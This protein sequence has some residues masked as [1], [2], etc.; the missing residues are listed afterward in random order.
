MLA[1]ILDVQCGSVVKEIQLKGDGIVTMGTS[2]DSRVLAYASAD[3]C[4]WATQSCEEYSRHE[5]YRTNPRS[6]AVSEDGSMLVLSGPAGLCIVD[7]VDGGM[8]IYTSGHSGA[9]YS[10]SSVSQSR[11]FV[12]CGQDSCARI[13]GKP[14]AGEDS[15]IARVK[16]ATTT[17]QFFVILSSDV[18]IEWWKDGPGVSRRA[19]SQHVLQDVLWILGNRAN[20]KC[21][22]GTASGR[23]WVLDCETDSLQELPYKE[24]RHPSGCA[25]SIGGS[26][27]FVQA[28][29]HVEVWDLRLGV[30][31]P[32]TG[33]DAGVPRRLAVSQDGSLLSLAYADGRLD[34]IDTLTGSRVR[35]E[36]LGNLARVLAISPG[37]TLVAY[38]EGNS[39][40][41]CVCTWCDSPPVLV[42]RLDGACVTSLFWSDEGL[43]SGTSDGRIVVWEAPRCTSEGHVRRVVT[44]DCALDAVWDSLGSED[45]VV[46]R[47]AELGLWWNDEREVV[48]FFR[49]RIAVPPL[50]PNEVEAL[51]KNLNSDDAATRESTM[52]RL[53]EY[54]MWGVDLVGRTGKESESAEQRA[55]LAAVVLDA[56]GVTK[57][58]AE[59]RRQIRAARIIASRCSRTSRSLL[60]ELA[61][62]DE[63]LPLV[64]EVRAILTDLGDQLRG[65]R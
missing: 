5:T 13:W 61:T 29:D 42:Y 48:E 46:A 40:I 9:V 43:V 49:L 64:R 18:C 23:L 55:R 22:L 10:T 37:G 1:T 14:G 51:W 16:Y 19:K 63:R 34:L 28:S 44:D 39:N 59:L 21:V 60:E 26:R 38:S 32:M 45:P 8:R 30:G 41:C 35:R 7:R 62:R 3:G 65:S 36:Q 52:V 4:I 24:V 2:Q 25:W 47:A 17:R 53:S 33:T 11:R 31:A 20:D 6:L 27:L 57:M 15:V 56:A 12:T 50:D 58:S 54:G